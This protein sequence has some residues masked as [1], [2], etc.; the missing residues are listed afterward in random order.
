MLPI[1][2]INLRKDTARR[3]SIEN[4]LNRY[5]LPHS[6]FEAILWKE[7]PQDQKSLFY[8]EALNSEQHHQP[9]IDGE[10]GCYASHLSIWSNLL[11]SEHDAIIVLEDDVKISSAFKSVIDKL[12]LN[13]F[14]WDMIKLIGRQNEKVHS[15]KIISGDYSLIKYRKIPSMTAG[16]II[17]KAGAA[18]LCKTRIPFGRPIDLDLRHWWENDLHIYGIYPSLINLGT[19]SFSSSIGLQ[20]SSAKGWVRLKKFQIKFIYTIKNFFKSLNKE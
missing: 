14:E 15:R 2:F 18:K 11:K 10:K 9:L 3:S 6:R 5:D 16:Y 1:I 17:N 13:S 4:E 20:N 12:D 7:L 8:S 19:A